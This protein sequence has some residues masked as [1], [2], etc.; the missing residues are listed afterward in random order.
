MNVQDK[1]KAEQ[2]SLGL[3]VHVPFCSSTCDFCAFY[4]EKPR[5]NSIKSYIIW[6]RREFMR[7]APP[8]SVETIFIGGGTP[9]VLSSDELSELCEIVRE[10]SGDEVKEWSVEL[11][12][13][14]VTP[15]KLGALKAGGV[16]RISLGVQTFDAELLGEMGRRHPPEKALSAYDLIRDM[17]FESINLDLIF[18][19]PGQTIEQ[20]EGDLSRAVE[21]NPDHISTYCLTFEEDTALYARLA[22][23]E[24]SIDPEREA[25]FYEL[26][27]EYLPS[28]GY[29]QYEVSNFARTGM[30]SLHNLN[31]W[32]MNEWLGY[33]PS[34]ASQFGG[35]RY[36]N[37]SNLEAWGHSLEEN[38][39]SPVE[40]VET[41][42]DR[43]LAS[44]S[45]LFG[46]RLNA[47]FDLGEIGRRFSIPSSAFDPLR[48]FFRR[49]ENE[50]LVER[51]GDRYRLPGAGRILADAIA[52]EL[53][54]LAGV[55]SEV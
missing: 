44:D 35:K 5:K 24:L 22:K 6:L 23:G 49:F 3:Y 15:E 30:E 38:N 13:N 33:G 20:W 40:D 51:E 39:A 52:L 55:A 2:N 11:A 16:T 46:L 50:G 21:L 19:A 17:G 37:V 34:A 1:N 43:S 36:R 28:R 26:A 9:G 48:M 10:K 53:P 31:T 25:T 41:L 27:W 18:G 7:I 42:S 14:E 45:V 32:R 12:P 8:R 29:G 4:Q 54:E 47:G